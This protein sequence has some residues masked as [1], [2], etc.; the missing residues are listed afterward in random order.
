MK[1]IL[2]NRSVHRV[3]VNLSSAPLVARAAPPLLPQW[4]RV[5]RAAATRQRRPDVPC[6]A[7]DRASETRSL[8][9]SKTPTARRLQTWRSVTSRCV[10][11]RRARGWQQFGIRLS[12]QHSCSTHGKAGMQ[13]PRGAGPRRQRAP[14]PCAT[15]ALLT[16]QRSPEPRLRD[17]PPACGASL[18]PRASVRAVP[19]R[20][21][22]TLCQIIAEHGAITLPL[23]TNLPHCCRRW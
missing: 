11:R 23:L 16:A 13:R 21:S 8:A 15:V 5:R 2:R 7:R 14:P 12:T 3:T 17:H 9:R 6:R 20:A 1:S 4:R 18:H 19:P 22:R 10:L